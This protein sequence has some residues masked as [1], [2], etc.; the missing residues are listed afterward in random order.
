MTFSDAPKHVSGQYNV[1]TE[2]NIQYVLMKFDQQLGPITFDCP[3]R[4]FFDIECENFCQ[5]WTL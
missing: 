4:I 2:L 1:N 3:S 5:I